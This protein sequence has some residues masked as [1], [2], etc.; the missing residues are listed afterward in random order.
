MPVAL[1]ALDTGYMRRPRLYWPVNFQVLPAADLSL[2]ESWDAGGE[3]QTG[4][5]ARDKLPSAG[6]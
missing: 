4:G 1:E 5:L 2:R 3:L 6:T